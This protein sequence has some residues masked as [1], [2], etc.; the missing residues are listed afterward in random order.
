M[1]TFTTTLDEILSEC[2]KTMKEERNNSPRYPESTMIRYINK[3]QK[4]IC[5]GIVSNPANDEKLQKGNLGFI[6]SQQFYSSVADTSISNEATIGANTL[7]ATTTNNLNSGALYIDGDII[8]YTS[9]SSTQFLGVEG[10]TFAHKAGARIK[11]LAVLPDAWGQ[12]I[13]VVYNKTNKLRP[14]DY[15]NLEG[16]LQTYYSGVSIDRESETVFES[17]IDPFY[18]ILDG[19][20]IAMYGFNTN[21][22]AINIEYDKKPIR[23]S[24]L[25]DIATIPDDFAIDVLADYAVANMLYRRGEEKR[26]IEHFNIAFDFIGGMYKWYNSRVIGKVYNNRIEARDIGRNNI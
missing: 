18:S 5:F 6:E 25:T 12:I 7:D 4:D 11:Q 16:E 3:A 1:D 14:V 8:T 10:I 2:Y 20:Y 24:N 15:R 17:Q 19:K 13:K 9:K 23:M 21:N 26:A 22:Y